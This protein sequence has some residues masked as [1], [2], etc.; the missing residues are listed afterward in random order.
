MKNVT[1]KEFFTTVGCGLWQALRWVVGIFGYK[2]NSKFGIF[3]R[4]VFAGSLSLIIFTIAVIFLISVYNF[5]KNE[6]NNCSEDDSAVNTY[7]S[8]N[9]YYHDKGDG[10]GYIFNYHTGE[11]LI[12]HVAWI[13]KP[14]DG[15]SLVCYSD[16]KKRGYF[17]AFTGK[18]AIEPSFNRA[19][20][21]SDGIAAVEKDGGIIFIDHDGKQVIH[22]SFEFSYLSD[23]YCF[24]N[25]YSIIAWGNCHFGLINKKGEWVLPPKYLDLRRG[26]NGYWIVKDKDGY[27]LVDDSM[28]MVLPCKYLYIEVDEKDLLVQNE[29]HT[30]QRLNFDLSVKDNFVCSEV[31]QMIY[32]TDQLDKNG[33]AVMAVAACRTYSVDGVLPTYYGLLDAAGHPLTKPAYDKITAVGKDLYLCKTNTGGIMLNGRGEK[34]NVKLSRF[35]KQ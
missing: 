35:D 8:R 34:V 12:N 33:H 32:E 4:R 2:D 28:K 31:E 15:D 19:W 11:T 23:G 16:G 1:L 24:H 30:M 13:A 6:Y 17:N 29:D 5:C 27:G 3:L 25:G 7:V 26:I 9:I 18:I 22:K 10:K 21:F 14:N 20:V